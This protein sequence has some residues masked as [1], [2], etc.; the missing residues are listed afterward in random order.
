VALDSACESIVTSAVAGKIPGSCTRSYA[1]TDFMCRE[2]AQQALLKLKMYSDLRLDLDGKL[3]FF[4][5][6]TGYVGEY[7]LDG[8]QIRLVDANGEPIIKIDEAT[9]QPDLDAQGNPRYVGRG[10]KITVRDSKTLLDLISQR[11]IESW[12][13]N[14]FFGYLVPDP[15]ELEEVHGLEGFGKRFNLLRF[16]TP[17]QIIEFARR[18]IRERTEFLGAL[19]AGQEGEEQLQGVV[20]VWARCR[21]PSAQEIRSYYETYYGKVE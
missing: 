8:T 2:Q 14:P 19:F 4:V 11:K 21:I 10:E 12:I 13:V 17:E 16:Y 5:L 15:R 18:D 3:V 7:D 20:G 6:N 9:S 1:A